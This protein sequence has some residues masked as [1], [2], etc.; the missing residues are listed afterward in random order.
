MAQVRNVQ[1]G[2]A[3]IHPN[4]DKQVCKLTKLVIVGFLIAT[5]ALILIL[6]FGGWSKLEG[7]KIVNFIWGGLYVVLGFYILRWARGLLPIAAALAVL[8][9]IIAVIAA[10]GLAGTSWF[11]R[12][13]TGFA[14]AQSIFGGTGLSDDVLG[15]ITVIL[16]PVEIALIVITM[17]GFAQ[18]WNVELEVPEDEARRRGSKP[19]ARG[20][21][22]DRPGGPEAATA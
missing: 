12:N 10:F 19:I 9:L 14:A 20:P 7:M 2:Y 5:I 4:R 18:D 21:K 15:T 13:T 8:L 17:I 11:D 22:V 1:P 6:T 16:I 3:V